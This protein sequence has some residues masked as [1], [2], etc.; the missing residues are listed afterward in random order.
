[1]QHRKIFFKGVGLIAIF[2]G[3]YSLLNAVTSNPR[4]AFVGEFASGLYKVFLSINTVED[5][6]IVMAGCI[7]FYSFYALPMEALERVFNWI[8]NDDRHVCKD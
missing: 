3:Y 5:Y 7:A 1:M 6:L 2:C 8:E 4:F